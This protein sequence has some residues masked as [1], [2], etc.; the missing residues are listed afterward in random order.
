MKIYDDKSMTQIIVFLLGLLIC[1]VVLSI[2]SGCVLVSPTG[3]PIAN[4]GSDLKAGYPQWAKSWCS[5][6]DVYGHDVQEC[7]ARQGDNYAVPILM[8]VGYFSVVGYTGWFFDMPPISGTVHVDSYIRGP[9]T[10][11]DGTHV[12]RHTVKSHYRRNPL[13]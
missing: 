4:L 9:Y 8:V 2:F 12:R 1:V 5:T 13:R 10:R 7:I 11:K 3:K 6:H